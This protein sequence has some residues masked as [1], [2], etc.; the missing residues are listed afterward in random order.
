MKQAKKNTERYYEKW[1]CSQCGGEDVQQQSWTY[2]NTDA[3]VDYID[4]LYY[5]DDCQSD[6]IKVVEESEFTINELEKK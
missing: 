4:G 5:C 2:I 6:E 3:L 1:V